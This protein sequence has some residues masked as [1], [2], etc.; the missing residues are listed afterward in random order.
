[1][2]PL[3]NSS[4][5][6]KYRKYSKLATRCGKVLVGGKI[7]E[8]GDL[9]YGFFVEPMIVEGVPKGQSP[10]E[11]GAIHFDIIYSGIR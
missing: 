11:R 10:I 9:K 7:R 8:D 5:Y 3:I 4:A 1:M 6:F 2:G